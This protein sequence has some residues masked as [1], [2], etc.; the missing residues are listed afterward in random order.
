MRRTAEI[1]LANETEPES[2]T[3]TDRDR[4]MPPAG[5]TAEAAK[6]GVIPARQTGAQTAKP[7]T[8]QAVAG[9]RN[10]VRN[11]ADGTP[12]TPSET[13]QAVATSRAD[14]TNAARIPRARIKA[15]AMAE[16][17]KAATSAVESLEIQRLNKQTGGE[18]PL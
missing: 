9:K 16:A 10:P 5:T 17:T 14:E 6:V 4:K 7:A 8:T 1:A 11:T 12:G 3:R 15:N 13:M 2:A 18:S